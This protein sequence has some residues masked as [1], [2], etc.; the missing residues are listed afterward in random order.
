MTVEA[1]AFW[2]S[3]HAQERFRPVYPNENVVRFLAAR[4]GEGGTTRRA[5]DIGVGAGR[6][7]LL[8]SRFGYEVDGVDVSAQGLR[9][10][11]DMITRD[12]GQARMHTA[13]M[14]ALP[15]AEATFDIAVS[16]GVFY[17]GTADDGRAAIGELHRVLKPGGEAF[18]VVRSTDDY[19]CGKG[20]QI[21]ANTY[22]LTIADTNETGTVQHFLAQDDVP[23]A[24][25]GFAELS[26]ELAEMTFA[27]RTKRNSDWLITVRK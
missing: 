9:H 10:A 23:D 25:S 16:F 11:Q 27:A 14:D 24:Y 5:L 20:D 8:L 13:S 21:G 18:V 26:F 4:A 15:F 1:G 17:Y 2:D 7:S 6:H 19:R 12:G 22:R 3:L